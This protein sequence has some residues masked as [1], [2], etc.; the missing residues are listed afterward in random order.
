MSESLFRRNAR[1]RIV[2][3]LESIG[4]ELIDRAYQHGATEWVGHTLNLDAGFVYAVFYNGHLA[5]N[6]DRERAIGYSQ[7]MGESLQWHKGW[8]K[9]GIP[10]GDSSLWVE[11]WLSTFKPKPKGFS[12][13]IANV[14]YYS[15]ILEEGTQ[16]KGSGRQY[17]VIT[18]LFNELLNA[19]KQ[20]FN[21]PKAEVQ[22]VY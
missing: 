10:D 17:K 2:S 1:A 16:S 13:V 20:A 4:K 11:Y 18:Y 7:G 12:L 19:G 21:D 15:R 8:E 9:R 14:A 5:Y 6:T 3:K 22:I